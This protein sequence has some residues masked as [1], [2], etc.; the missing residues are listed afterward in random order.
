VQPK[1]DPTSLF[2]SHEVETA[3][4]ILV[5]QAETW[6]GALV[7]SKRRQVP[8]LVVS[9]PLLAALTKPVIVDGV[10]EGLLTKSLLEKALARVRE[11]QSLEAVLKASRG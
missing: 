6:A 1:I 11:A 7:A 5:A 10:T 4:G 3:V 8:P 2:P 9:D